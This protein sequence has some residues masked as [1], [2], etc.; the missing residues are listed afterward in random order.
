MADVLAVRDSF[1][2]EQWT[3]VLQERTSSGLSVRQFCQQRGISEKSYYYWL[4]KLRSQ[5]AEAAGPQLVQLDTE[6]KKPDTLDIRYRGA[7]IHVPGTADLDAVAAL[8][9]SIQMR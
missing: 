4:K 3:M 6:P 1:R 5:L 2:A 9:R 7:E 8:L